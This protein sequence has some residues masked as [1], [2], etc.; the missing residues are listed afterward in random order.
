M[1]PKPVHEALRQQIQKEFASAYYY[2]SM[3]AYFSSQNLNGFAHWMR[4]QYSE[5]VEHG[6][7]IYDFIIERGDR[8]V[9][10]G[11]EKPS[12][13]FKTPL[14]VMTKVLEHEKKVTASINTC[15]ELA[16]KE[17]DYPTQIMLEWFIKE[18]VEEER[19][20]EEVINLLKMI[21]DAPAGLIMLDR[22]LAA[23]S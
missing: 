6:L 9:L 13:D 17:K 5:E 14:D 19:S 11:I 1:I 15:Y 4:K 20:A 10:E 18:Q 8:V 16:V 3:S 21:G 7:K 12:A 2:L 23:R 22:Q